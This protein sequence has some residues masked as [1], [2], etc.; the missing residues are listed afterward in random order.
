M[1]TIL[2]IIV[3]IGHFPGIFIDLLVYSLFLSFIETTEIS[4]ILWQLKYSL[5]TKYTGN[6][7]TVLVMRMSVLEYIL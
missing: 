5:M 3:N 2:N 4:L 6:S 1:I 7:Y